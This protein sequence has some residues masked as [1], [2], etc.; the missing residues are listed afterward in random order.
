MN[1]VKIPVQE[2]G[3]QRGDGAYFQENMVICIACSH[4][5][6]YRIY[7]N[8]SHTLNNSYPLTVAVSGAQRKK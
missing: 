7:L 2:L 5:D 3:G 1:G 6:V 8:R 4:T